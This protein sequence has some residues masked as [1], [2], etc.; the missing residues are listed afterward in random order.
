MHRLAPILL[1]LCLLLFACRSEGNGPTVSGTEASLTL[2][3]PDGT[4]ERYRTLAEVFMADNEGITVHVESMNR[5]TGNDPNPARALAQSADIF[6]SGTAFAGDW[7]SLTLDLTPYTQLTSFDTADF[8]PAAL[9]EADGTIR[10]LP[11]TLQATI[12]VYNKR[13]FDAA[14]IAYPQPGWSW[15]TFL[16]TAV[17]LTIHE[18]EE[19]VQYGLA[20]NFSL[21]PFIGLSLD[22]PL[23][24]Y[25]T[26][27]P[28]PRLTAP[29]VITATTDYLAL[30]TVNGVAPPLANGQNLLAETQ[31]L[32][33]SERAAMWPS[34]YSTIGQYD[35]LD[36]GFVPFPQRGER[37]STH[38]FSD[39]FAISAATA[40][41]DIAWQLV[42][43]LSRQQ[44]HTGGIPARASVRQA[45]GYWSGID[46]AEQQLIETALTDSYRLPYL[47]AQQALGR[48]VQA[49]VEGQSLLAALATEEQALA[50]ALGYPTEA[51]EPA[52]TAPLPERETE[53]VQIIFLSSG[54]AVGLQQIRALAREFESLHP[55]IRIE[56]PVRDYTT[57]NRTIDGLTADC[58]QSGPIWYPEELNQVLNL[59][60]LVELDQSLGIDDFYQLTLDDF[61]VGGD[62][63]ALPAAVTVPIVGYNKALFD[64]AG[65]P[66]PAM[67]WTPADF[68]ETAVIL[69]A[70]EGQYGFI[71]SI[72]EYIEIFYFVDAFGLQLID[73]STEP[74]TPNF[75]DPAVV[76]FVR[77]Y[78]DFSEVHQAKP[79]FHL[80][81]WQSPNMDISQLMSQRSPL[82]AGGRGGMWITDGTERDMG[83]EQP[84]LS[85]P[86]RGYVAFPRTPN[87]RLPL[88]SSSG[89]YISANTPHRDACWTWIS[90]LT[91]HDS[92]SGVPARQDVARA[93]AYQSR[94]GSEVAAVQLALLDETSSQ[95][96]GSHFRP[97]WA[98]AYAW[99]T[100]GIARVIETNITP[101][102]AM[103]EIQAAFDQ[104]WR[105]VADNNLLEEY[106]LER[107]VCVQ[108]DS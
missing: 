66:Y 37:P 2:A 30:H 71:P 52:T 90:F 102:E 19:T 58:F 56:L 83:I 73:D 23:V 24:D 63:Y 105:C 76:D 38:L 49:A 64:A 82:L 46:E 51:L 42:E 107:M 5:L 31:S 20:D 50:L 91:R 14:G 78:T 13:L 61:T 57:R 55:D 74:P 34:L 96:T 89:Y 103:L 106:L 88:L 32:I 80:D 95:A 70:I 54:T 45:T 12:L 86:H 18:G 53:S 15:E 39:G 81:F 77:W 40:Q 48:A 26:D 43:F 69:S 25:Q 29:D 9:T 94:I 11:H 6:P 47:Q 10:H 68:L 93:E 84:T 17:A 104:Y 21:Y 36:I 16:T 72:Q 92:G 3:V 22:G 100:H 85:L 41:P 59:Q 33:N 28:R 4:T 87:G 75:T 67:D 97:Q 99:L 65:L 7:Q 101:A 108:Q 27:P 60:P 79:I 44:P 98:D 62:L 35:Q 1:L 8:P